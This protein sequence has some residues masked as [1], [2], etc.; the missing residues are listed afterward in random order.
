MPV[1]P[2]V[3]IGGSEICESPRKDLR[4]RTLEDGI[5]IQ[6]GLTGIS[7]SCG[8]K[9]SGASLVDVLEPGALNSEGV[10]RDATHRHT[11]LAAVSMRKWNMPARRILGVL[12][13][14]KAMPRREVRDDLRYRREVSIEFLEGWIWWRIAHEE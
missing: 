9:V 12:V 2:E 11:A 7:R 13:D 3:G 5:E 4:E 10:G 6:K 8:A 1:R 14:L